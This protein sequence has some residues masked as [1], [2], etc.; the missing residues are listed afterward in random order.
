MT[1]KEEKRAGSFTLVLGSKQKAAFTG[2]S[3]LLWSVSRQKRPAQIIGFP[4]VFDQSCRY[5]IYY[6]LYIYV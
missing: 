4:N 1:K 2:D 5:N 3:D 6:V